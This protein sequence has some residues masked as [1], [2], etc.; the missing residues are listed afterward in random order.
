MP[1]KREIA[2][3][4]QYFSDM[5]EGIISMGRAGSYKYIDIDDII[6]QA[7]AMAQQINEGGLDHPVPLFGEE[8]EAVAAEMNKN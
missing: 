2:H 3:A 8:I 5:P 6:D 7:M 4:Q 1:I